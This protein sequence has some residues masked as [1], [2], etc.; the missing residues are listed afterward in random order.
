MLGANSLCLL[1]CLSLYSLYDPDSMSVRAFLNPPLSIASP[2]LLTVSLR[3][4][5]PRQHMRCGVLLEHEN[6]SLLGNPQET[7]C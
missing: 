4:T 1:C 2:W 5:V 3:P 7:W 6:N